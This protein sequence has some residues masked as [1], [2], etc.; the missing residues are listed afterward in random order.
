MVQAPSCTNNMA[1]WVHEIS[2]W[3]FDLDNTLYDARTE[4]FPQI[5][6]RMTGYM[7]GMLGLSWDRANDLRR[8]YWVEFGATLHGLRQIH[9]LCPL[10]FTQNT[11][12]IDYS[13][14]VPCGVTNQ[15]L[16][17]LPGHKMLFTN[18]P[19][20]HAL[21]VLAQRGMTNIFA[22]MITIEDTDFRPKPDPH[23]YEHILKQLGV[24]ASQVA[25]FEDNEQNLLTARSLGLRTLHVGASRL[26]YWD[27]R[28]DHL[29]GHL[30]WLHH[31][32]D[33]QGPTTP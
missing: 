27:R 2:V 20:Q 9:G 25:M 24:P 1:S 14:L 12:D 3:V 16:T 17:N 10:I 30:E 13:G 31:Q 18:G 22:D 15:F 8:T 11:H 28:D 5:D 26:P 19:R 4:I 6:A 33:A 21:Q 23:G 32:L 29:N 7:A